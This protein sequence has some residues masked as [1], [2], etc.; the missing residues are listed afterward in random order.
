MLIKQLLVVRPAKYGHLF[1]NLSVNIDGCIIP[2]S[3]TVKNL[4]VIFDSRLTFQ[5]HIKSIIKTAFFHLSNIA[6]IR[7]ILSL[8]DIETVIHAF[9]S[10]RLDFCNV[11]FSGL[12]N[13]AIRSLQLVQNAAA[14]ILT[15]T[16]NYDHTTPGLSSLLIPYTPA[17]PLRSLDAA[18]LVIPSI[19]KKSLGFRAFAYRAPY[20]WNTTTC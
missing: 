16:R 8:R 18:L 3:S 20:L 5:S 12:P 17:C 9:V 4:G 14:R 7:P 6:K 2:E 10:S 1:E 13:C 19:N 15:K 11:L